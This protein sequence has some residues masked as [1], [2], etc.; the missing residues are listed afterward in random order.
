MCTFLNFSG[1]ERAVIVEKLS[2][3]TQNKFRP[4]SPGSLKKRRS[5]GENRDRRMAARLERE[6]RGGGP[7]HHRNDYSTPGGS[8][9]HSFNSSMSGDMYQDGGYMDSHHS[10]HGSFPNTPHTPGMHG[11]GGPFQDGFHGHHMP[12]GGHGG[13]FDHGVPPP[14]GHD[15]GSRG[16]GGGGY[17]MG[18]NPDFHHPDYDMHNGPYDQYGDMGHQPMEHHHGN[19]GHFDDQSFHRKERD[20]DRFRDRDRDRHRRGDYNRKDRQRDSGEFDRNERDYNRDRRSGGGRDGKER[21]HRD[22]RDRDNRHKDRHKDRHRDQ[23]QTPKDKD[24]FQS[25]P[26]PV[27]IPHHR[28]DSPVKEE[29]PRKLSLESRIASLLRTNSQDSDSSG[30]PFGSP[31]SAQPPLPQETPPPLPEGE[32]PPLPEPPSEE[33]PPLPPDPDGGDYQGSPVVQWVGGGHGGDVIMPDGSYLVHENTPNSFC[34]IQGSHSTTPNIYIDEGSRASGTPGYENG[35]AH[36]TPQY[37]EM[38]SETKARKKK[39]RRRDSS[40][41]ELDDDRMSLA[42]NDSDDGKNQVGSNVHVQCKLPWDLSHPAF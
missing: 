34:D 35:S 25:P 18:M 1:K 37:Q 21:D 31:N 4:P 23:P 24:P 7:H 22:H 19:H 27:R 40:D 14:Y 10:E 11:G 13:H 6:H 33:P 41:M 12:H 8:S 32:A 30:V 39:S 2:Q 28:E 16:H 20:R 17:D 3:E 15:M 42:S 26:Q 29:E 5:G 9:D 38:S 36:G